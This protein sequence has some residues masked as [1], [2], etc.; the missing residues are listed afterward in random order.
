MKKVIEVRKVI[1]THLPFKC[2][3]C[4]GY[5]TVGKFQKL[6]KCHGCDGDGWIIVAQN[7]IDATDIV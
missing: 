3:I 2:P 5:G 4:N 7:Y 6:R 1:P